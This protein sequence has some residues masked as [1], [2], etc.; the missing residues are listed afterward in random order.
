MKLSAHTKIIAASIAIALAFLVSGFVAAAADAQGAEAIDNPGYFAEILTPGAPTLSQYTVDIP[1]RRIM[2]NGS[3]STFPVMRLPAIT[4]GPGFHALGV[5]RGSGYITAV[6]D[7]PEEKPDA[8]GTFVHHIQVWGV[9]RPFDMKLIHEAYIIGGSGSKVRFFERPAPPRF[10]SGHTHTVVSDSPPRPPGVF[11]S[12]MNTTDYDDVYW[13]GASGEPA[14]KMFSAW[15][16][17]V[18]DLTNDGHFEI[19]AWQRMT[20]DLNCNFLVESVHSYPEVYGPR[21]NGGGYRKIWPPSNWKNPAPDD[22]H[23]ERGNLDAGDYQVQATFADLRGDKKFELIVLV[24]RANDV[25]TQW[26]EAYELED[27]AFIK[28]ATAN[29]PSQKIAFM[30]NRV[31]NMGG[32][33][34][35]VSRT[36]RVDPS[37][38]IIFRAA[39]P[40][41]CTAGG[42]LDGDGTSELTYRFFQGGLFPYSRYIGMQ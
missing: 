9:G 27:N 15:D 26:L 42:S 39:T 33:S 32:H 25:H 19:V 2:D 23:A 8:P 5:Y 31:E 20:Y 36:P 35:P 29:L 1:G 41:K 6:F 11:I 10:T 12:I 18:V 24:N 17:D 40:D 3:A 22:W 38:H 16:F 4:P 13:L 7:T 37:P 21:P 28:M 34:A 14:T 30:I